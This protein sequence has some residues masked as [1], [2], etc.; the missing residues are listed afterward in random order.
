MYEQFQNIMKMGP[1]SQIL[2]SYPQNIFVLSDF[3][4]YL[5]NFAVNLNLF[6]ET[7]VKS[8]CFFRNVKLFA[9]CDT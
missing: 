9:Y 5:T 4:F 2:V 1:F 6:I 7:N 3:H 8:L